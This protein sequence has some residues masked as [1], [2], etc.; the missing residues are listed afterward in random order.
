VRSSGARAAHPR[1]P[2]FH[3]LYT[4]P[5]YCVF[6]KLN[7]Y[8]AAAAHPR[9]PSFI[10]SLCA[11][12]MSSSL[13]YTCPHKESLDACALG[14]LAY[15]VYLLYWYR[16]LLLYCFT[17][18]CVSHRTSTQNVHAGHSTHGDISMQCIY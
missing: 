13:L 8:T 4:K 16:L 17:S 14:P 15:P 11:C 18:T 2:L 9:T 3:F 12:E 5:L 6:C 10:F 7:S 1:T